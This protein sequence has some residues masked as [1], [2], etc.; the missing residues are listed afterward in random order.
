[1]IDNV[2]VAR[3][4]DAL[5]MGLT[6]GAVMRHAVAADS[7][8]TIHDV[9]LPPGRVVDRLRQAQDQHFGI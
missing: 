2:E 6:D 4:E 8:L 1:M 3:S 9:E 7:A 5:S